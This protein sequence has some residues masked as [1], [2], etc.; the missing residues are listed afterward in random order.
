MKSCAGLSSRSG[1][2]SRSVSTFV[3]ALAGCLCAS[4]SH[5]RPRIDVQVMSGAPISLRTHFELD[6]QGVDELAFT[7]SYKSEPL[8]F[9]IYYGVRVGMARE[10]STWSIELL[11]HKVFLRSGPDEIES[12]EVTHG[13]NILSIQRGWVVHSRVHVHIGLGTVVAHPESRVRGRKFDERGGIFDSGYHFAGPALTSGVGRRFPVGASPTFFSVEGARDCGPGDGTRSGRRSRIHEH[14]LPRH[15]RLR[16]LVLA[17]ATRP[18]RTSRRAAHPV[19]KPQASSV[20]ARGFAR[21]ATLRAK[22]SPPFADTYTWYKR[23]NR[24]GLFVTR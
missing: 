4:I 11:H 7:A 10:S 14:R 23:S 2:S 5:A 3:V 18:S 19:A 16:R 15:L 12:F 21:S 8:K 1:F 20:R 9:P 6:Q 24:E 17:P 22:P 13:F